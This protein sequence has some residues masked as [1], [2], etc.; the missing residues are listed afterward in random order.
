MAARTIALTAE[1]ETHRAASELSE[2]A[3]RVKSEFLANMSLELRTSLHSAIR[4]ADVLLALGVCRAL[5]ADGR[6]GIVSVV[7]QSAINPT[8]ATSV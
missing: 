3:N 5:P 2:A 8:T 1:K 6:L 7:V 4:C